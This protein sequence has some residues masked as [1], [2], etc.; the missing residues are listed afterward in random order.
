MDAF[1]LTSNSEEERAEPERL[2][3]GG[4]EEKSELGERVTL[5]G[6]TPQGEDPGRGVAAVLQVFQQNSFVLYQD[7]WGDN[8]SS[9]PFCRIFFFFL[10]G[11]H[12]CLFS[13][14]T[15]A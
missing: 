5:E 14:S 9:F 3:K 2:G 4:R 11:A 1:L 13:S 10:D 12:Q 15:K 8:V 6:A 7:Q